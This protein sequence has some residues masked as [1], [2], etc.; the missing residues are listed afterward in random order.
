MVDVREFQ[1]QLTVLKELAEAKLKR[2]LTSSDAYVM[3]KAT[4]L[5]EL[6]ERTTEHECPSE[7]ELSAQRMLAKPNL[8]VTEYFTDEDKK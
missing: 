2:S 1:F 7:A 6:I 5:L 3:V 4:T 8:I